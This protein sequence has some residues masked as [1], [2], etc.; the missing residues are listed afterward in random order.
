MAWRQA[1][2]TEARQVHSLPGNMAIRVSSIDVG[3]G[4]YLCLLALGDSNAGR[5]HMYI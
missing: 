3:D 2:K 1:P 5:I 4:E